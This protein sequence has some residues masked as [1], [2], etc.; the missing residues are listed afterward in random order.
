MSSVPTRVCDKCRKEYAAA[1]PACP[2]C[3]WVPLKRGRSRWLRLLI[4]VPGAGLT[5]LFWGVFY[6]ALGF[7]P[8]LIGGALTISLANTLIGGG[9]DV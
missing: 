1:C 3:S 9:R 6:S 5:M 4:I 8:L 2:Y 7:W